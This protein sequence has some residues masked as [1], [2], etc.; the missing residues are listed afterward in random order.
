M[1]P[2]EPVK[3]LRRII[4]GRIYKPFVFVGMVQSERAF[5]T[6][7]IFSLITTVSVTP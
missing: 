4:S 5:L 6:S 1:D 7:T 3:G 2:Y